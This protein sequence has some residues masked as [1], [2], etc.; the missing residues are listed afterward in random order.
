M[1]EAKG[2]TH[3]TFEILMKWNGNYIALRRQSIPGHEAPTHA[4]RY[5]SGLLY[6][7]HNLIR[8]GESTE[9]CVKRI[10]KDQ[11]G[12]RIRSYK[13]VDLESMVQKKDD[14][15]AIIPTVI[16]ELTVKPKV[17]LHGNEVSEVVEFTKDT[18]PTDFAWW[19]KGSVAE[20]LKRFD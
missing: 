18:V 1:Y 10:V 8:Y 16:A 14:Q 15:W 3:I 4:K 7:C 5:P 9:Q 11:A 19:P 17:G 2:G 13:V 12:V 6:F 20:F